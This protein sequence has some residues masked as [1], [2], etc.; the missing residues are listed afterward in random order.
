MT[1]SS[2]SIKSLF[3]SL[4]RISHFRN[5]LSEFNHHLSMAAAATPAA[6]ARSP[7]A[8]AQTVA[9]QAASV[10]K[11]ALRVGGR[12]VTRDGFFAK[13]VGLSGDDKDAQLLDL[14]IAGIGLRAGVPASQV[15]TSDR[16]SVPLSPRRRRS[17]SPAG[18]LRQVPKTTARAGHGRAASSATVAGLDE[19]PQDL[20]ASL[21][22][23]TERFK[24]TSDAFDSI[25]AENMRLQSSLEEERKLFGSPLKDADSGP[26]PAHSVAPIALSFSSPTKARVVPILKLPGA[27][28]RRE[29]PSPV[30]ESP[31]MGCLSPRVAST[32]GE[33]RRHLH[34]SASKAESLSDTVGTISHGVSAWK[35]AI[36]RDRKEHE[37]WRRSAVASPRT[38]RSTRAKNEIT[39]L[40]PREPV[41]STVLSSISHG[42]PGPRTPRSPRQSQTQ[43]QQRQTA[44]EFHAAAVQHAECASPDLPEQDVSSSSSHS[45]TPSPQ[46]ARQAAHKSNRHLH[47]SASKRG[48]QRGERAGMCACAQRDTK[49]QI[50]RTVRL[51]AGVCARSCLD[52]RSRRGAALD[53]FAQER[54]ART[55]VSDSFSRYAAR[56]AQ[57]A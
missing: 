6:A 55:R 1:L 9:L 43:A 57:R 19:A 39:P 52:T 56:F 44:A 11:P 32:L 3:R 41:T 8:G 48:E 34:E 26:E 16:R 49:H 51:T 31:S 50:R 7:E 45:P 20:D 4:F 54:G 27:G 24:Q 28:A 46:Q 17:L 13:I 53:A 5:G 42:P 25:L 37:E 47:A 10:R 23:E 22:E 40:K 36:E 29:E 12:V 18:A 38:P 15:T 21:E 35:E 30:P 33:Q 14:E 2:K